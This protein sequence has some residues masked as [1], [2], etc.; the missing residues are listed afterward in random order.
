MSV[1]IPTVAILGFM[2]FAVVWAM[3][4]RAKNRDQ[5]RDETLRVGMA[6]NDEPGRAATRAQG[7]TAWARMSDSSGL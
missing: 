5:V 7:V 4:D 6:P 3:L 1:V 2:V